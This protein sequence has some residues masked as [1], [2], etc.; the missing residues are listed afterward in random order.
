MIVGGVRNG[1]AEEDWSWD[2][3]P[4]AAATLGLFGTTQFWLKLG[5][6]SFRV[7]PFHHVA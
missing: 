6:C 4:G 7:H 1:A 2:L 3:N 5:M